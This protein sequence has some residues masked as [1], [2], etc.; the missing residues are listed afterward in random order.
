MIKPK[1]DIIIHLVIRI[2]WYFIM[3][4]SKQSNVISNKQKNVI[5]SFIEDSKRNSIRNKVMFLLSYYCGLRSCEIANLKWDNVYLENKIRTHLVIT[6]KQSK[7]KSGG[8]LI[9]IHKDLKCALEVLFE[10]KNHSYSDYVIQSERTHKMSAASVT[11]FFF[12]LYKE[13]GFK[14]N[15]SS[16]S[17]RR[18]FCNN[19]IKNVSLY[20]CSIKD[21][22]TLM[23][24]S[25]VQTTML[26]VNENENGKID[27][28][29]AL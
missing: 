20:G 19:L 24:H 5:L 1:R 8:R 18:T 25:N 4:L 15:Y 23:G 6:N 21:V 26:Y 13:I 28:I 16:H 3:A 29:K 10:S 27:L 2:Y 11:N 12:K 22:Q 14:G 17:G 7:G 9:P